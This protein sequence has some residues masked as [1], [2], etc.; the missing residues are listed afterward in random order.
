M[1]RRFVTFAC[2]HATL[3]GTL[4][5]A[6][7]STGLLIVTGGNEVRGG[8]WDGQAWFAARIAAKGFP[9]LRFDRRG[10]GDSE[11]E[12]AG[13]R[14]SAPD[15]AAAIQSFRR[16]CPGITRIVGFGNCDAASALMLANGAG[17]DALVL[18]NPWTIENEAVGPPPDALRSHY[19]RRL[20]DPA[21]LR[22]LLSGRVNLMRLARSLFSAAGPAPARSSL[23][24]EM[25][26]GV[27]EF[28]GPV[29][30]LLAGRDRTGRAFASAWDKSDSRIR[31]CPEAT[32]SYVGKAAQDWLEQQV[33][34]VLREA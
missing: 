7:G 2:G 4:D 34:N 10:I 24:R 5:E 33:L 22:R 27:A 11:G 20:V 21:A 25:A 32:H 6:A 16:E 18:S 8:A 26:A 12:N 28:T 31:T 3:I 17:L 1:S 30:I 15:M 29:R 13:F 23:A 9:V 14:S 19:R